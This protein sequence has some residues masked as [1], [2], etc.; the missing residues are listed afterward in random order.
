MGR[1]RGGLDEAGWCG[2]ALVARS[3]GAGSPAS[4][5]RGTLHARATISGVE[6]HSIR[7]FMSRRWDLVE[8]QKRAVRAQRYAEGGPAAQLAAL[9]ELRDRFR[10]LHPEGLPA[11]ARE[12]DLADQ[13]SLAAKLR[14]I[15]DALARS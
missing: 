10:R 15:A 12:Q 9:G 4:R 3:A 8:Q 14:R 11:H 5:W 1:C 6:S 13:V 2:P 7:E